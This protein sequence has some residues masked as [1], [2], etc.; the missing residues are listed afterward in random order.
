MIKVKAH[1]EM[2]SWNIECGDAEISEYVWEFINRLIIQE[3]NKFHGEIATY[4]TSLVIENCV[5]QKNYQVCEEGRLGIINN[6]WTEF[7]LLWV[8]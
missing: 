7:G 2:Y 6:I 5:N 3:T 1:K 8:D 4:N